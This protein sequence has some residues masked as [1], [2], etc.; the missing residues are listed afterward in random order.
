MATQVA[1]RSEGFKAVTSAF[2]KWADLGLH[3]AEQAVFFFVFF[4]VCGGGKGGYRIQSIPTTKKRLQHRF[5]E[6][7]RISPDATFS[8]LELHHV[9]SHNRSCV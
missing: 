1:R 3:K 9:K 2:S 7:E 8:M 6:P 4:C 5:S